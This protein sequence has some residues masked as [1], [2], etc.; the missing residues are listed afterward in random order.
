MKTVRAI[1]CLFSSNQ[2]TKN[3]LDRLV[4]FTTF[5]A[6]VVGPNF[7][8]ST[9][10]H[11]IEVLVMRISKKVPPQ[12]KLNHQQLSKSETCAVD[13]DNWKPRPGNLTNVFLDHSCT[14]KQP[15]FIK[16]C[17]INSHH[18][19]LILNKTIEE[20]GITVDFWIIKVHTSN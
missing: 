11:T 8:L 2:G 17:K 20:R 18:T 10:I 6:K 15:I 19:L 3:N 13:D 14:Y 7:L 5:Q 16:Y 1:N 12:Q 4:I 9:E